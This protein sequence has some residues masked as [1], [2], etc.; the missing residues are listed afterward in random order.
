MKTERTVIQICTNKETR[1]EFD[2][3]FKGSTW[4]TKGEFLELLLDI[5]AVWKYEDHSTCNEQIKELQAQLQKKEKEFQTVVEMFKKHLTST[6]KD[7]ITHFE[8]IKEMN[9]YRNKG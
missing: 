1:E 4:K 8:K 9:A 3:G 2:L 7:F 6:G 5:Y